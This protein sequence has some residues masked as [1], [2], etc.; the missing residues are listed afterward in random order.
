MTTH[1]IPTTDPDFAPLPFELRRDIERGLVGAVADHGQLTNTQRR[2]LRAIG[3]SILGVDFDVDH[4]SPA[5]AEELAQALNGQPEPVRHRVVQFMMVLELIL[6]P[7]P[8][9]VAAKVE[10]YAK[11]L[12]VEDDLLTVG[13]DYAEGAFGL[14]L[15]DLDRNGYFHDFDDHGN[16]EQRLHVHRTLTE[17][18][19]H[20][21]DDAELKAEWEQLGTLPEGSLG[22]AVWRFYRSRGFAFP[23]EPESVAPTLAQ[24]D[25]IHVLADYGAT[26]EGEI[27]TFAFISSA[28][29]N[30]HGFSWLATVLGVFETGYV[31]TAAGGVLEADRG[32]LD[33]E[34]MCIRLADALRRG[35]EVNV[36][37]VGGVDYFELASLPL[38]EAQKRLNI[39]PKAAAARDAGSAGVDERGGYSTWQVEHGNAEWQAFRT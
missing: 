37:L 15:K 21:H 23:G 36:D 1:A 9:E 20:V 38:E 26:M 13:R 24:H 34:G 11:A 5:S 7:L 12:G 2:I 35:R 16:L 19:E 14:A 17:P 3:S 22:R 6:D 27:E 39:P 29:P 18:F 33:D 4:E 31:P 30:P 8:P 10:T 28:D 25:F 32:H